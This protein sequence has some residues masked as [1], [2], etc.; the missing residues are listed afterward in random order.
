MA[1]VFIEIIT[2]FEIVG[3]SDVVEESGC[4]IVSNKSV[5]NKL[6]ISLINNFRSG[7]IIQ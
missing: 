7:T 3:V 4:V 1:L 2:F 5:F 6:F